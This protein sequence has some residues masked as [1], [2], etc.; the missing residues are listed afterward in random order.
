MGLNPHFIDTS[1]L[2]SQLNKL[3][4]KNETIEEIYFYGAGCSSEQKKSWMKAQ[5][6]SS[7]KNA[8]VSV[9]SDLLAAAHATLDEDQGL[10]G[11]LG[12]GSNVAYFDGKKLHHKSQ[13]LG[14]ILGDEGAGSYLGKLFLKSFFEDKLSKDLIEKVSLDKNMVLS[15]LYQSDSP[16]KYLASFAPLIFRNRKHPEVAQLIQKNFDHFFERQ[17]LQYAVMSISLVGSLAFNFNT[18]LRSSAQKYNISIS[19][20]LERPISSLTNYYLQR[21][22]SS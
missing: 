3:Q 19:T 9:F 11:I 5:L 1:L 14:Y 4:L 8:K 21:I 10:I 2:E 6:E 7:F 22:N 17:V 20:I 12:T 16:N 13:N 18:E 15:N